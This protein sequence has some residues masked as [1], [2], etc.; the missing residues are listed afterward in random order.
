LPPFKGGIDR[1]PS[2]RS[3]SPPACSDG[4]CAHHCPLPSQY[5]MV[6]RHHRITVSPFLYIT[7]EVRPLHAVT[8]LPC[9]WC[10]R[11]TVSSCH[12]VT[13]PACCRRIR[14][15]SRHQMP[16]YWTSPS[17]SWTGENRD[18]RPRQNPC[19]HERW[20][21]RTVAPSHRRTVTISLWTTRRSIAIPNKL[22][23]FS[24]LT[25]SYRC[26]TAQQIVGIS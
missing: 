13:V 17:D 7:G 23:T 4:S 15:C 19:C 25:S 3:Y 5:C 9:Y 8:V 16:A 6:A 11:A 26:T 14:Q 12:R 22:I 18:T 1:L 10:H 21:G 2:A 20:H 24:I